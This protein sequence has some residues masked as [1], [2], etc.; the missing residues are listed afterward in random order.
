MDEDQKRSLGS[1]VRTLREAQG[2]TRQ[3]LVERTGADPTDRVSLEMLAKVEQGKK[4]P[5]AR[6]LRKLAI[7]LGMEPSDLAHRA[8]WWELNES[9]GASASL[10]RLG[11]TQS[12]AMGAMG[13]LGTQGLGLAGRAV[14]RAAPAGILALIGSLALNRE[15]AD[16]KA[17]SALLQEQAKL[18]AEGPE[19]AVAEMTETLGLALLETARLR[20]QSG[21]LRGEGADGDAPRGP[22]GRDAG[23]TP[24]TAE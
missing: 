24:R 15:L 18:I 22:A 11:V 9:D 23:D 7:A 21:S 14:G 8:A 4:A 6:T 3:D 1:V 2:L 17:I 16:R 12:L 5:S 19:S 13:A 10:L 20:E